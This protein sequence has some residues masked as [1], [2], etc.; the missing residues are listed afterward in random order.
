MSSVPPSTTST[1]SD[2]SGSSFSSNFL[3]LNSNKSS[4]SIGGT[5]LGENC[6]SMM[7]TPAPMPLGLGFQSGVFPMRTSAF[8]PVPSNHMFPFGQG[9]PDPSTSGVLQFPLSSLTVPKSIGFNEFQNTVLLQQ[10]ISE[11]KSLLN[12]Q[13]PNPNPSFEFPIPLSISTGN[14]FNLPQHSSPLT[15]KIDVGSPASL[16]FG[17]K[18]SNL[19]NQSELSLTGRVSL[20]E[21]PQLPNT[22][23]SRSNSLSLKNSACPLDDDID[24]SESL[25]SEKG[26]I[27]VVSAQSLMKHYGNRIYQQVAASA[28]QI[29]GNIRKSNLRCAV[30]Q[31]K[32]VSFC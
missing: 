24:E 23:T 13:N 29:E 2:N 7:L 9:F 8:Q 18:T 31:D 32:A 21:H 11:N 17:R 15:T 22:S 25:L 14:E 27:L 16:Q 4:E 1:V 26:K 3:N 6:S 28:P 19:F 30:C 12:P 20:Q 5:S 10:F